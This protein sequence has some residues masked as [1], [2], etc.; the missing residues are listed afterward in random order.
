MAD[1]TFLNMKNSLSGSASVSPHGKALKISK[2]RRPGR[3]DAVS[4]P[5]LQFSSDP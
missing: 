5:R 4:S 3:T 2:S 1:T